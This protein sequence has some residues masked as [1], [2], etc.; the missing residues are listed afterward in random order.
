MKISE[1]FDKCER[2]VIVRT[3]KIGDMVLTLPLA[4]AL[5]VYNSKFKVSIIAD[6]YTESLLNN[7]YVDS[8]Y[9]VDKHPMGIKGIFRD[10][11]FDASFFPMPKF[12]EVRAAFTNGIP[13]RIGSA[14]RFYS[15]LFNHKVRDHRKISEYHEAEYN[16]RMLE[17]ITGIKHAVNPVPPIIS[18]DLTIKMKGFINSIKRQSE[19]KIIAVHPASGGSAK[20]LPLDVTLEFIKVISENRNYIVCLTGVDSEKDICKYISDSCPKT[21]NLCGKFNLSE[22]TAFL[23]NIDLLIANSTGV[24]HIASSLGT[25]VIGFYPNLPHI[26]ARRW[27]PL[28][29]DSI[30]ISPPQTGNTINDD[31]SSIRTADIIEAVKKIIDVK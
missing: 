11:K 24:L 16:V 3:D 4:R 8:Y 1:K 18:D 23:N 21:L 29:S 9:F 13:L 30:V 7:D 6:S 12:N 15:V 20:D 26:S 27:G 14:Y 17:S 19:N 10:N 28:W 2:I 5:K 22:M 31:M 25:P